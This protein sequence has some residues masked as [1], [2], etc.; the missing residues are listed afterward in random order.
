MQIMAE[1]AP[2]V[3]SRKH[4]MLNIS[5]V[6]IGVTLEQLA[7]RILFGRLLDDVQR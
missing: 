2:E 3:D 5:S 4:T 1:T 7:L 6:Y